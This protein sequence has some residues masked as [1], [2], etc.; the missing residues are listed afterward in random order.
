[1]SS[2]N[3]IAKAFISLPFLN[4]RNTEFQGNAFELVTFGAG[5]K[6]A[7]RLK[8]IGVNKGSTFLCDCYCY[9]QPILLAA[10][11]TAVNYWKWIY[12]LCKTV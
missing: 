8:K 7:T 9:I 11:S 1:M 3:C 12:F 4:F 10:V 6:I 5:A 2:V